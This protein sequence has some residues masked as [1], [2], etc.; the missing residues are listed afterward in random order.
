MENIYQPP[1]SDLTHTNTHDK[2]KRPGWVWVISI[3]F[4]FSTIIFPLSLY[5]A[6]SGTLPLNAAQ[7]AYYNNLG[8]LNYLIIAIRVILTFSAGLTLF[9]LKKVTI[10]IWLAIIVF[11]VFSNIYNLMTTEW[12]KIAGNTGVIGAVV[13][14]MIM[15]AIYFYTRR[16]EAR[17]VLS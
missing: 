16:L 7:Q 13:G 12:L 15:I 2:G 10:K 5:M 11:A 9:L 1:K 8:M 4:M 14:F 6:L 3:W 17:G